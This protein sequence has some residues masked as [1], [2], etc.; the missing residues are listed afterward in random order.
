MFTPGP[1][2]PAPRDGAAP[3]PRLQVRD[4]QDQESQ[5]LNIK[6]GFPRLQA[7]TMHGAAPVWR[8]LLGCSNTEPTPG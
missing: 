5:G 6:K 4:V 7:L 2:T 3:A 8:G 1:L